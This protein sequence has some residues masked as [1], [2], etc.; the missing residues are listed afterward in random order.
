MLALPDNIGLPD[1]RPLVPLVVEVHR[2]HRQLN[3]L[4]LEATATAKLISGR[5]LLSPPA[6]Q[7]KLPA[8]LDDEGIGW[9]ILDP[10]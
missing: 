6:A 5:V 1:P 8:I 3:L 2:R 10:H 9:N 7:G 4:N